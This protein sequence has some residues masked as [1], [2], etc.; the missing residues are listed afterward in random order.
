MQCWTGY[1]Q[2]FHLGDLV[3]F[4][5]YSGVKPFLDISFCLLQKLSDQQNHACCTISGNVVQSSC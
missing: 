4:G 1:L 5:D 3:P 2:S